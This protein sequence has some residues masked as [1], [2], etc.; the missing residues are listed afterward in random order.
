MLKKSASGVHI[1][2]VLY[3]AQREPQR[4]NIRN[5]VCLASKTLG[6]HQL[7]PVRK[8]EAPYARRLADL[9]AAP[10][11]GLFEH[12][13]GCLGGIRDRSSATLGEIP[14]LFL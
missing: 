9:A 11:D 3:S 5:R 2:A 4:V 13:V 10:L 8:R 7:A 6:A 12:P 1:R 14:N